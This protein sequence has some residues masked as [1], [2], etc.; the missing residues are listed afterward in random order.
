MAAVIEP[1]SDDKVLEPAEVSHTISRMA[2]DRTWLIYC[3]H[4]ALQTDE[5]A[6][7]PPLGEHPPCP[8]CGSGTRFFRW[9]GENAGYVTMRATVQ[10]NPGERRSPVE[11]ISGDVYSHSLGRMVR[12]HRTI[13]RRRDLYYERVLDPDTREVLREVEEPLS[14]H[15]GRGSAK[16]RQP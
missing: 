14:H 12:I 11:S 3:D 1:P 16:R 7:L 2:Q 6:E 13:D 8:D 15:T 9:T 4:C 10:R 5:A